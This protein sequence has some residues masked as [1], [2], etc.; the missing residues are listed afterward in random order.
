MG[1]ERDRGKDDDRKIDT[2]REGIERD[3][4][5]GGDIETAQGRYRGRERESG[6][7]G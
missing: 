1:I 3:G 5:R 2:W 6:D 4:G 7:G